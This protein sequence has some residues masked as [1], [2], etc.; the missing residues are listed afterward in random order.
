MLVYAKKWSPTSPYDGYTEH[1]G[2][3]ALKVNGSTC[4]Q[5]VTTGTCVPPPRVMEYINTLNVGHDEACQ[6]YATK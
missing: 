5:E 1:E 6:K 4:R 3:S 2:P